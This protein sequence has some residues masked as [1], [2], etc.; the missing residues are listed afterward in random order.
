M[1]LFIYLFIFVV[2]ISG[3]ART[4]GARFEVPIDI[5]CVIK[6]CHLPI[7]A[8]SLRT[9]LYFFRQFRLASWK[10]KEPALAAGLVRASLAMKYSPA[11]GVKAADSILR[12]WLS[13]LLFVGVVALSFTLLYRAITPA[14]LVPPTSLRVDITGAPLLVPKQQL[15]P[16][17]P[18]PSS[19]P[20]PELRNEPASSVPAVVP[21]DPP[22]LL[23]TVP[24]SFA[25]VLP[26]KK[27][28]FFSSRV[29][30]GNYVI[31]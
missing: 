26:L 9:C 18:H 24:V 22:P 31:S 25:S 27:M 1:D 2:V 30:D 16:S 6:L 11:L 20:P 17:D 3:P 5:E 7:T 19:N 29:S 14:I 28:R 12:R 4:G 10:R 8:L 23:Y 21:S 15:V 13:P